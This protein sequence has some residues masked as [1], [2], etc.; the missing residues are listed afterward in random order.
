MYGKAYSRILHLLGR[1]SIARTTKA[2]VESDIEGSED[3]EVDKVDPVDPKPPI[4]RLPTLNKS[5]PVAK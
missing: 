4:S 2:R 5:I 1:I 3:E